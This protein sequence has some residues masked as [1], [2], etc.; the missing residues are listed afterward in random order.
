MPESREHQDDNPKVTVYIPSY[1]YGEYVRRSIESVLQ[2]NYEP[3]EL[4][5]IDDG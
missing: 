2:Q 1:N 3:W 5:V 4:I